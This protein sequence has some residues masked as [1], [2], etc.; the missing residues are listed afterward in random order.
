MSATDETRIAPHSVEAEEAVIGSI[1]IN[2]EVLLD[3][4][5]YLESDNFFI[6]RHRWIWEAIQRLHV[7]REAIDYF[8]V[9]EELSIAG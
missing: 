6:V 9:V 8:T 5:P 3:V 4:S 1:L 7:R 2:P